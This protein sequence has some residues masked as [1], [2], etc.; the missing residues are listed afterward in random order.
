MDE[1]KELD[2]LPIEVNFDE[3][4]SSIDSCVDKLIDVIDDEIAR[5][6]ESK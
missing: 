5:E 4:L 3:E 1:M 2:T 6:Y